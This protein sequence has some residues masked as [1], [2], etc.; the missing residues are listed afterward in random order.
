MSTIF[1]TG[2]TGFLG[3]HITEA[4]VAAGHTV[5][6][7]IRATSDTRWLDP[8][9]VET[10]V[11]D[12]G[13][14]DGS[15]AVLAG[16]D[17]LVHCGALTRARSEAEFMAVNAAGTERLAEAAAR[18]GVARFVFISSLA[19][20]G[21]DG[22]DGPISPYGRSKAVAEASLAATRGD[23]STIVLRPGGVYGPRDLD[24]LPLFRLVDRGWTII[25]RSRIP[26]QPVYITD[27][28]SAVVAALD[29]P[30]PETPLAIAGEGRHTWPALASALVSAVGR[31]GRVVG[32]PPPVFWTVGLVAELAAR[33]TGTPPAMDR[34]RARDMS[35][36]AWTCETDLARHVL[37]PW[38]PS[39]D[40][41][42]GLARTAT[43]YREAGWL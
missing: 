2:G 16:I 5:T 28:V 33:I 7:S 40:I 18:A 6:C 9:H 34:S 23:M 10:V 36:H 39:V 1:L 3:S 21:P 26:L 17:A 4:L 14:A 25:P 32:V 30:E 38:E 12:L 15:G 22:A 19:A 8:L 29:A 24:L 20:R 37:D 13:N 42:E 35:V 43:W 11:M 27:V 31:P 41:E